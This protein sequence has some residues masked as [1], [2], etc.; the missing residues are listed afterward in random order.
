MQIHFERKAF[1][2]QFKLAAGAVPTRDVKPILC[3]VKITADKK[4][5]AVLHA[6]DTEIGIRILVD[7]DVTEDGAVLVP[8]KEFRT[9]LESTKDNHLTLESKDG[10]WRLIGKENVNEWYSSDPDEFPDVSD[11]T[12][13]SYHEISADEL[14]RAIKRTVF[15]VEKDG[16]RHA[17]SG[18]LFE[19]KRNLDGGHT[20]FAV[21]TDGRRMAVQELYADCIGDHSLGL[22]EDE[23][24][25]QQTIVPVKTL[26][27]VE[28]V[29]KSMSCKNVSLNCAIGSIKMAVGTGHVTFQCGNVTIFSR[30]VDGKFPKWRGIIPKK[31]NT[32]QAV[33]KSGFL[34]SA[35]KS[36]EIGTTSTDFGITLTFDPGRLTLEA[37]SREKAE[38]KAEIPVN[39]CGDDGKTVVK[40]D[41]S[42][43]TSM[44]K[45]LDSDTMLTFELNGVD[46]IS[47]TT[48]DDYLYLVMPIGEFD[49]E[50]NG[51]NIS[52]AIRKEEKSAYQAE[53]ENKTEESEPDDEDEDTTDEEEEK[54]EDEDHSE[55]PID[56]DGYMGAAVSHCSDGRVY[57]RNVLSGGHVYGKDGT[58]EQTGDCQTFS[59]ARQG[60][61]R[62]R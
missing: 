18:V 21:A 39:L 8:I 59:P 2:R 32:L 1:L 27:L 56:E 61:Y 62:C 41:P 12:A 10:G 53:V 5:G 9:M 22:Y 52:R 50:K 45:T 35:V 58:G 17:L 55:V 47:I 13:E 51:V 7:V 37:K 57:L 60:H 29:L 15:A 54:E 26:Q 6:T 48:S 16:T 40:I 3:N 46:P 14:Y 11:F 25:K 36:V 23:R 38:T 4:F 42:Y 31:N 30:L 28:K 24:P 49:V 34:L 44:L 33:V 20:I 19:S 43:L